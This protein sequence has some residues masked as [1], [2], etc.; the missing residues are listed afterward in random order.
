[1]RARV[2]IV[3]DDREMRASLEE[4]AVDEGHDVR[5]AASGEAALVALAEWDADVVVTD[6]MMPGVDGLELCQRVA[7]SRPDV[8]VIVLTAQGRVEIAIAAI[9]AGAYDFLA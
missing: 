8:P 5:A 6:V 9:R 4:L 3:D 1:M 2:L 7:A